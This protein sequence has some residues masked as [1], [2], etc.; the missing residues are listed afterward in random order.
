MSTREQDFLPT[1]ADRRCMAMTA[2]ISNSVVPN[3]HKYSAVCRKSSQGLFFIFGE[4]S[5]LS[6]PATREEKL[7]ITGTGIGGN[8]GTAQD[9]V[10]Q[11]LLPCGYLVPME[12][13]TETASAPAHFIDREYPVGSFG[14]F[15]SGIHGE[16]FRDVNE[17]ALMNNG[18]S[19]SA[20]PKRDQL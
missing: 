8:G 6:S 12:L 2:I 7:R 16:K 9:R 18:R 19:T 15:T 17:Q 3:R 10:S 4:T 5:D 13:V 11:L 1:S 14:L 20:H